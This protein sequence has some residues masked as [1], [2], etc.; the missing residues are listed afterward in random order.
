MRVLQ[1]YEVLTHQL[2]TRATNHS[3]STPDKSSIY[4]SIK[5]ALESTL[6]EIMNVT[7]MVAIDGKTLEQMQISD[8]HGIQDLHNYMGQDESGVTYVVGTLREM[9]EERILSVQSARRNHSGDIKNLN[10]SSETAKLLQLFREHHIERIV[11]IESVLNKISACEREK[12]QLYSRMRFQAQRYEQMKK[13]APFF[14]ELEETKAYLIG[15]GAALEF[16]QA[17]QE[18]LVERVESLEEQGLKIEAM[19][20]ASR[21][22]DQK[23]V[24]L[25]STVKKL[26]EMIQISH[27]RIPQTAKEISGEITH[28]ISEG[29]SNLSNL[30]NKQEY[31]LEDDSKV[32][33]NLN[34]QLQQTIVSSDK[35]DSWRPQEHSE[36]KQG[37]SGTN[38]TLSYP[39]WE[40]LSSASL[41]SPDQF[42]LQL[43]G[44]QRQHE[45]H[46]L[47]LSNT[48]E[49]NI[50]LGQAK[51]HIVSLMNTFTQNFPKSNTD[52]DGKL[53]LGALSSKFEADVEENA[54]CLVEYEAS[55]HS[56]L[57]G[58]IQ[59]TNEELE[60][61]EGIIQRIQGLIDDNNKIVEGLRDPEESTPKPQSKKM[62]YVQ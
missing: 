53:T 50:Q 37:N 42:V 30:A 46:R 55:R 39:S 15:L 32:L 26:F 13:D 2:R 59:Q 47:S 56:D 60:F 9:K 29:L 23:M 44:A 24:H 57:L 45:I 49:E 52:K 62:R 3:L 5:T 28:S 43:A 38:E 20:K 31:T 19:S 6:E 21:A 41:L 12:S 25:Q 17:E 22:V 35:R 7:K 58:H 54:T 11:Q 4:Y 27:Q 40:E 48:K 8:L 16:I 61:G 1:E 10:T 18:N 36:R 14:Q 51:R 34:N 33:Q